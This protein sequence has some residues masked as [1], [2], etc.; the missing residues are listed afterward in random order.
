[1]DETRPV[2]DGVPGTPQCRRRPLSRRAA[3]ALLS[4]G[5][6]ALVAGALGPVASAS[7]A[8]ALT[9]ESPSNG[10]VVTDSTPTFTGTGEEAEEVTLTIRSAKGGV[11]QTLHTVPSA[12]TWNLTVTGKG[13]AAGTYTAEAVQEEEKTPTITFTVQTA[14]PVVT[15]GSPVTGSLTS[16]GSEPVSG[17][18]GEPP[19]SNVTI[20]LFSG[21]TT[22]ASALREALT[23][24]VTNGSW[25]GVFG[26]LSVG[27][28]TVQAEQSDKAGNIGRSAPATFSVIT[29]SIGG[30]PPMASFTWFPAAPKTGENVSLVSSSTD[31]TSPITSFA[32]A[33]SATGPFQTGKP[34]ITTSFSTPG[35]HVARLRITDGSG[36]ASIATETIPVTSVPLT[37]M[38]PF[39][40]VRIAGS[41]TSRG[42]RLSLLSAEAPPGAHVTVTC[43]GR[44]CPAKLESRVAVL[45]KRKGSTLVL[46][47]R[48][49]ERGLPA[50][51]VLEIRVFQAGEIGKYTRF[52]IR[53]H[54]LPV[55]LDECLGP[56]GGKPLV[57]PSS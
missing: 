1:M 56:T 54:R 44:G 35:N 39:P 55:R 48:R 53:H 28:Y 33:L 52:T 5:V 22:A 13:L 24:P 34:V 18:G 45:S 10:S 20:Q 41:E 16:T 36:V 32:W 51:V 14:G 12:G 6:L 43:K 7:A 46:E 17:T 8:V 47:F 29:P 9:I 49:F 31:P 50:G 23:V 19:D 40:I 15:L 26:G 27:T 3:A 30:S 57:C 11:A 37:L 38:Q 42:A 21:T 25:S 4:A 2:F